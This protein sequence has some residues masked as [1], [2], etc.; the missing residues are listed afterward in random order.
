VAN[1]N[2]RLDQ[3]ALGTVIVPQSPS[4]TPLQVFSG[5]NFLGVSS[6]LGLYTYYTNTALGAMNRNI[7]SFKL[8]RGYSATFAQNPDGAGISKVYVA[9]DSDL[10]VGVL[11]ISLD[12]AASFVRVFPWRW[13]SK[14]GWAGRLQPLV[15]PQW[16]YDWDNSTTSTLD[17]E[18]VPMRHDLNWNAYANINN[19][20]KSTHALGFNEPDK[21]DQANMTVAA[22][23]AAWPNLLKSGLRLGSPAPSDGGLSSLYGFIH[24]ADALNYRVDYVAVHFY[25]C[26]QSASQLYNWLLGIYQRTG[27]PI[28]LTEFNNGANWTTCAKPTCDQNA[29]TIGQWIDMLESTPFVERYSIY[30][31]VGTNRAMVAKD[32][33]LTPAGIVYRDKL[34]S[35]ACAQ[36]LPAGGSRSIAQFQFEN[37]TLDSSGFGNNGF[38][39]G[40]PGYTAG[41]RGQAVTLDGT[42]N[43]I[44]LPPNVA[45]SADFSFAA[46]VYW[47]GGGNWQ[48]IFD[49]GGD[50]AHYLFLTPSSGSGTLR[51]AIRNGGSEQIM[52][53]AAM[54]AGHW[55]HLAVTVSRSS[56]KLYTN[57]VLAASSGVITNAPSSFNPILNYLGKSQFA[58]D[59]LFRGRLDEMLIADYA[60]TASQIA[61]LQTNLPP[62]FLT[63]IFARGAATQGQSYSN[64]II[65]SATDPDTGDT[66]TYS[67]AIGPAWL[68][69]GA[70]GVLTGSPDA[71]DAGTNN[72]TVRVTDSAGASAFAL[73]TINVPAALA[74][75]YN[76]DDAAGNTAQFYQLRK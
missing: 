34:S 22:A 66:L 47:N 69:V 40:I 14:K 70:N 71:A 23:I 36:T 25:K 26:G 37:N 5:P 61:A 38:S 41:H 46:W 50:T 43:F 51:F 52:E 19:K 27:R 8:K 11:P 31:W 44:Q 75:G 10:E 18:Y 74:Q 13:T 60:L 4:F 68:T 57:G 29:T 55:R 62:Q 35:L 33:T 9:Q 24:E 17:T 21:R 15:N 49:F 63:N 56:A 30:N 6:Q 28:W 2:C 65:G 1:S 12:H 64:N 67:K 59:P 7:G 45:H 32:G 3:Y 54:P 53:T 16:S 73:L 58:A 72:F 42:N 20:Q 48:R 76:F 39:V